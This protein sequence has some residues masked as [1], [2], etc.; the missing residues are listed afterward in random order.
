MSPLSLAVDTV[1]SI[2]RLVLLLRQVSW[3]WLLDLLDVITAQ[4]LC[5]PNFLNVEAL[6]HIPV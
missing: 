2:V 6:I 3:G 1:P 5:Q 4:F